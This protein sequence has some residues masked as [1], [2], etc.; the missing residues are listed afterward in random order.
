MGKKRGETKCAKIHFY[1]ILAKATGCQCFRNCFPLYVFSNPDII[2]RKGNY[3]G[4]LAGK[5]LVYSKPPMGLDYSVLPECPEIDL[6]HEDKLYTKVFFPAPLC[7]IPI[8]QNNTKRTGPWRGSGAV[9]LAPVPM[10]LA[11]FM[12]IDGHPERQEMFC[13]ESRTGRQQEL[14]A[15]A[16]ESCR[17]QQPAKL[18]A[19]N[20]TLTGI[21]RRK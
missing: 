9:V 21:L 7:R 16:Q 15:E 5:I 8:G 11:L 10:A 17:N 19:A 4:E 6:A 20:V 3:N 1:G 18:P 13:E 2:N 12:D 14:E